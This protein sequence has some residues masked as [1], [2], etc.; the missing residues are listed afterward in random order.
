M[1]LLKLAL[2]LLLVSP[3]N[4]VVRNCDT[5]IVKHGLKTQVVYPNINEE[6]NLEAI[7]G[8]YDI[9]WLNSKLVT[10]NS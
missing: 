7:F 8:K 2:V 6:G 10:I 5:F 1:F 9:K 4:S 3:V